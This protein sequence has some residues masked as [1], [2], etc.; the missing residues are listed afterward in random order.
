MQRVPERRERKRDR[1][2]NGDT[3]DTKQWWKRDV[4]LVSTEVRFD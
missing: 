2:E 4:F 3:V 1:R